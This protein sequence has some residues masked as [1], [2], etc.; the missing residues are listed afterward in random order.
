[1][2]EGYESVQ[3]NFDQYQIED[4]E[5][6]EDRVKFGYHLTKKV[7]YKSL[8]GEKE[9][10]ISG[11]MLGGCLDVISQ[12]LGTKYDRTSD[13]LRSYKEGTLWYLDN[14]EL[15]SMEMYRRLWKMRELGWFDQANG[16]LIGRT[17]AKDTEYFSFQD[18]LK[19]AL[20]ELHVPIIYDVDIGHVSPQWILIN[21]SYGKFTYQ[22]GKGT[23]IQIMER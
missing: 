9:L 21:G 18:A 1:M 15:S 13:Y 8:Y 19:R 3:Q 11:R 23:L 6:L 4:F 2:E 16:F 10:S 5:K 12:L 20:G 7:E 17:Y 14:C 22:S